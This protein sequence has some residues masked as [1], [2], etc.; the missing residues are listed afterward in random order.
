[1]KLLWYSAA[2]VLYALGSLGYSMIN[3]INLLYYTSIE[4]TITYA[5]LI[6][7]AIVF[8]I[9]AL[10][11]TMDWFVQ[12]SRKQ[13]RELIGCILNIIGSVLYLIGATVFQNKKVSFTDLSDLPASLFNFCGMLAFLAESI[14]CFSMPRVSKQASACSIEF[15]A[16]LLNLTGN[17]LYLSAHIIQPI[18]S[19]I[20][21][22]TTQIVQTLSNIIF[23]VIRPIQIVGDIIY[24]IDAALYMIVWL[25][26]NQQ[27]RKIGISCIGRDN[28][29]MKSISNNEQQARDARDTHQISLR[30]HSMTKVMARIP[31]T[32]VEDVESPGDS[33]LDLDNPV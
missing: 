16:H 13:W 15:F 22:M 1:M 8:I 6:G 25:K 18:V 14:L 9:D 33:R 32:I 24:T 2:N 21:N 10:L 29:L 11:Y 19:F 26:A 28:I 4:S 31:D 17:L 5:I 7:L 12:R 30:Q 23:V 3:I 27:I 20:A